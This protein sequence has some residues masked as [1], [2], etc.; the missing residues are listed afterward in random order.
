[1]E[2]NCN[3]QAAAAITRN[4]IKDLMSFCT[5]FMINFPLPHWAP[6]LSVF[7]LYPS[8]LFVSPPFPHFSLPSSVSLFLSLAPLPVCLPVTFFLLFPTCLSV[9]ACLS[10]SVTLLLSISVCLS[11]LTCPVSLS[12]SPLDWLSPSVT[13]FLSFL[14]LSLHVSPTCLP[15][16]LLLSLCLPPSHLSA[17]I[18]LSCK[19]KFER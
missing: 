10:P 12:P 9:S 15:V 5:Q 19:Q 14:C 7:H 16:M 18:C 4:W 6:C 13:H 17:C 8:L 11:L 1:M 3:L 2:F